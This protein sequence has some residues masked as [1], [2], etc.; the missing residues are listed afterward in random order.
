M[1]ISKIQLQIS[2]TREMNMKVHYRNYKVYYGP[3]I[4]VPVLLECFCRPHSIKITYTRTL[5]PQLL[6]T[7][8]YPCRNN[9]FNWNS[10]LRWRAIARQLSTAL[11]SGWG[12]V[13]RWY[14]PSQAG[15]RG[16]WGCN[17]PYGIADVRKYNGTQEGAPSPAPSA[18]TQ[19]AGNTRLPLDLN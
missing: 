5:E 1:L 4:N 18:S 15:A 13:W 6:M 3:A 17:M 19:L 12:L 9:S 10:Q 16:S 14:C 2:L 7:Y 11:H 8:V